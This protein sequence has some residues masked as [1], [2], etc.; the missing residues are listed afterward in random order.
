MAKRF[1][2]KYS[3]GLLMSSGI[4]PVLSGWVS[5]RVHAASADMFDVQVTVGSMIGIAGR[6]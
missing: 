4:S 3:P 6:T 2:G 5:R 1:G